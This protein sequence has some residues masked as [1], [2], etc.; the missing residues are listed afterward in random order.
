M[1]PPVANSQQRRYAHFKKL[2]MDALMHMNLG[3][4]IYTATNKG[5]NAVWVY[6][7]NDQIE[8]GKG[9]GIRL[10]DLNKNSMF[11]GVFEIVYTDAHGTNSPKLKL[12]ISF[13]SGYYNLTWYSNNKATEIGIGFES[14]NKLVA[15][16]TKATFVQ[17]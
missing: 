15:S 11:E 5:L 9:V 1:W 14:E 8:Q 3:C 17:T 12:V 13:E 16:Y 10:T 7:K 4:V 2:N 6:K